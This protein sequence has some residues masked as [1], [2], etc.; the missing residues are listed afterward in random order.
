MI[1]CSVVF[2]GFNNVYIPFIGYAFIFIGI[3]LSKKGAKLNNIEHGMAVS[4]AVPLS[5][6]QIVLPKIATIVF[7]STA[8]IMIVKN[9]ISV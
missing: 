6:T 8:I 3:L 7:T 2:F 5:K 9:H 1:L 4:Y